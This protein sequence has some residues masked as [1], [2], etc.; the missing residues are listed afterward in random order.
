MSAAG[1]ALLSGLFAGSL[2]WSS[3]AMAGQVR[4]DGTGHVMHPVFSA[5]GK[6]VAYEV[7]R[8][9][10]QVDLFISDLNGVVAKDGLKVAIPGGSAFGESDRVAANPVWHPSGIIV[11]EG[12]SDGGQY[13]L[14]YYQPGVGMASEMIPSKD[15]PGHITFPAISG[16]AASWPSWPKRPA[17]AMSAP[18]TRQPAS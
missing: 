10:G 5:D 2:F 4:F 17:T 1:R 9:A 11:F 16:T 6:H 3:S 7:N 18:G 15:V 13:R 12:S 14:Y 8:L